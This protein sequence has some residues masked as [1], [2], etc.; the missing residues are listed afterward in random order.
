MNTVGNIPLARRRRL[1][2]SDAIIKKD[3]ER[4]SKVMAAA[5]IVPQ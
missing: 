5:G 3:T 1:G 4:Y 2:E